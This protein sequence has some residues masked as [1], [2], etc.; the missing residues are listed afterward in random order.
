MA[1]KL[2]TTER[3]SRFLYQIRQLFVTSVSYDS[4]SKKIT[5]SKNGA[6]TDVVTL[7]GVATSGSYNDL[8]SKPTI[9]TLK[10]VFGK[11]K[12][13]TTTIEADTTQD[14]LEF[15]AGSNVTLTPDATNDKITIDATDT[16][17]SD[18]TTSAHGLMTASDKT[19]LN[20]IASG[21]EVNVQ[22]D[23]NQTTTTA[24]DYIKNKPTG[25][26]TSSDK[27][28]ASGVCPLD[29]SGK[30]SSSYLPSFVDD[31][32]EAYPRSGQTELSSTW[33]SASSG[34]SALTPETGKIYILMADSTN[35]ST[36]GQFRW[37]GSTY[38]EIIGGGYTLATDT[39]ID[40]LFT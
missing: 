38:V 10:N 1:N 15:V 40:A 2:V 14:T 36:N 37:S 11:V 25:I 8:S 6:S 30:V 35:Y 3:L 18:A 7:A 17:Y 5:Y 26:L 39:D 12:V 19:K 16:T 32:I 24:D 27:G 20:G 9:P 31:V 23:W 33:L 22:S 21:A 34:G 4:S 29:S 13:S 28:V